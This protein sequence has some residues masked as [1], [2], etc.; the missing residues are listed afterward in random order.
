MRILCA[1]LLLTLLLTGCQQQEEKEAVVCDG[2]IPANLYKTEQAFLDECAK[3]AREGVLKQTTILRPISQSD[4]FSL[5]R[6]EEPY[7]LDGSYQYVYIVGEETLQIQIDCNKDS[8]N[9]YLEEHRSMIGEN[10][11]YAWVGDALYSEKGNTWVINYDGCMVS[12]R[13]PW[14]VTAET[15]KE[16]EAYFT[17][18]AYSITQ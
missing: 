4:E 16:L 8:F 18:E 3:N 7:S 11:T 2:C 15:V 6:V 1:L 10:E 14:S 12:F 9:E 13:L 17:I 5:Y